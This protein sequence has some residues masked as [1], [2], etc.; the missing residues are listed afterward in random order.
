MLYQTG[1]RLRQPGHQRDAV[2]DRQHRRQVG[3]A[4]EEPVSLQNV[5]P[6]DARAFD[7][8]ADR[9]RQN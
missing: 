4:R 5:V 2:V 8:S 1:E 6:C 3:E 7:D 9:L